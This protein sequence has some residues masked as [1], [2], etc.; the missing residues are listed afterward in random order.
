VFCGDR[1]RFDPDMIGKRGE[2]IGGVDG[3][4]DIAIHTGGQISLPVACM[5]L[6]VSAMIGIL[7]VSAGSA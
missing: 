2:K 7:V 1:L 3:F 6:A 4:G 5:A